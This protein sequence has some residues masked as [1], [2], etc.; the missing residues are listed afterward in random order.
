MKLIPVLLCVGLTGLLVG[1][2]SVDSRIRKGQAD[3]DRWPAEVQAAIRA[4]R[5]EVGFT[6]EQVEMA[7]GRPSRVYTRTTAAGEEEI[8]AYYERKPGFSFG[9]AVGSGGYQGV[10]GGVTYDKRYD[11]LDDATR[12]VFKDGKVSTIELRKS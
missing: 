5:V 7:L 12:I 3:F 4:E 2:A 10:G 9:M 1:C 8:W 6:P 11:S